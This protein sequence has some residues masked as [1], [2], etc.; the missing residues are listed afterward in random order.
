MK[1]VTYENIKPL[2]DGFHR[3]NQ[4]LICQ[5]RCPKTG[6]NFSVMSTIIQN[7]Q[8]FDEAF[9]KSNS[10]SI[11]YNIRASL[12][13]KLK[14]SKKIVVHEKS[15]PDDEH[16]FLLDMKNSELQNTIVNA[17]EQISPLFAWDDNHTSFTYMGEQASIVN[18]FD[19]ML[20]DNP[21]ED[22]HHLELLSRM[23]FSIA[24]ADGKI[25][26]EEE[27]FLSGFLDIDL[28]SID[29][30]IV[31][32]PVSKEEL[33]TVGDIKTRETMLMTAWAIAFTDEHLDSNEIENLN[34]FADWLT[35]PET[36]KMELKNLAQV[37]ILENVAKQFNQTLNFVNDID[38]KSDYSLSE[39]FAID[40]V[41][42]FAKNIGLDEMVA[43]KVL[44]DLKIQN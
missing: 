1:N 28:H 8:T 21:I 26:I 17:F 43:T 39:R 7:T 32:K 31:L 4:N 16:F 41:T 18:R 35:I 25:T 42:R 30:G 6:E 12:S 19:T 10:N 22:E 13:R 3:E 37:Y 34:R 36:R 14:P 20:N 23:L 29:K 44:N 38:A 11:F 5:F 24:F 9:L 27:D 15:D 33:E 2:V 40:S